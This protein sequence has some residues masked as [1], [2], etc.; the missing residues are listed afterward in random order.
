MYKVKPFSTREA[1]LSRDIR[2]KFEEI[3]K[4]IDQIPDSR[5]KTKALDHIEDA[6]LHVNI[7]ISESDID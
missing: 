1:E 2:S 3:E 5:E 4:L 6:M 7:A